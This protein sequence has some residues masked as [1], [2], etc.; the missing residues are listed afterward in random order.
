LHCPARAS[1]AA[2]AATRLLPL[3]R[4]AAVVVEVACWFGWGWGCLVLMREKLG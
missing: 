1:L 2:G 3:K 4:S